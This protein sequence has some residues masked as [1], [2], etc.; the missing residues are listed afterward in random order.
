MPEITNYFPEEE[1]K[2]GGLVPILASC[3]LVCVLLWYVGA[4]FSAVH[5]FKHLDFKGLIF[6]AVY[7]VV[8]GIIVAFWIKVRLDKTM[9]MLVGLTPVVL[10]AMKH[11]L[12][13]DKMAIPTKKSKIQKVD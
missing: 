13:P 4:T 3:I 5:A 12:D 1:P 9:W 11:G 8:L 2:K 6:V 10:L 7:L